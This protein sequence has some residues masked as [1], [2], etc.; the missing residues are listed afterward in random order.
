[1]PIKH[2]VVPG[3]GMA[4]IGLR[5]GFFPDTLWSLPENA[6]LREAR[7]DPEMLLA[8]DVVHVPDRRPRAVSVPTG[9]VHRFRRKGVP[10]RIELRLL[11][12]AEPRAGEAFTLDVDGVE[13]SGVTDAEG[14]IREW[15]SPAACRVVI[16]LGGGDE[17]YTLDVGQLDPIDTVTGVQRRLVNLGHYLGAITG[18]LDAGTRAALESFQGATGLSP[19]GELDDATRAALAAAH[20]DR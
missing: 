7:G 10:A 20:P 3:D 15:V 5:Y 16:S 18:T 1:M 9:K 2:E 12:Q 13:L 17:R 11:R 4:R 6:E 19:T 8:G 14:W